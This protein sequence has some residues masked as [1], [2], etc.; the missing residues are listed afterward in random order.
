MYIDGIVN[1]NRDIIFENCRIIE[2]EQNY[3]FLR[4]ET[5]FAPQ[6]DFYTLNFEV[7][8]FGR[9]FSTPPVTETSSPARLEN[10]FIICPLNSELTSG[11]WLKVQ[12]QAHFLNGEEETIIK[13]GIVRLAIDYSIIPGENCED[14]LSLASQVSRLSERIDRIENIREFS[15]D[16][17][18][19]GTG[20]EL[21]WISDI[22]TPVFY[23]ENTAEAQSVITREAENFDYENCDF[24][25]VVCPSGQGERASLAVIS[26]SGEGITISRYTGKGILDFILSKT[27][28]S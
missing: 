8:P 18:A 14:S 23:P 10:G 3:Q 17:F 26:D 25:S 4:I 22:R 21:L 16:Y 28:V 19:A 13:T 6:A 11:L 12:A 7:S 2:G 15:F 24:V 9:S 5:G 1:D 27:A 20:A